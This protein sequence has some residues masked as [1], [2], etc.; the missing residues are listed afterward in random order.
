MHRQ[1]DAKKMWWTVFGVL[2]LAIVAGLKWHKDIGDMAFVAGLVLGA[3][4][5]RPDFVVDAVKAWRSKGSS[6]ATDG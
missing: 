6:D 4:M 1:A 5:I 2:L 3:G